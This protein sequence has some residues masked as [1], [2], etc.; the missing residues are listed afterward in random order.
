MMNGGMSP[1]MNGGMSPTGMMNMSMG[2][3]N[4][5]PMMMAPMMAPMGSMNKAPMMMAP[6]MAPM[7]MMTVAATAMANPMLSTLVAALAATNLTGALSHAPSQVL[8]R[9]AAPPPSGL[10]AAGPMQLPSALSTSTGLLSC[11]RVPSGL[12]LSSCAHAGPLNDPNFKGTVFA[13]TND[14]FMALEKSM[15]MTQVWLIAGWSPGCCVPAWYKAAAHLPSWHSTNA[16]VLGMHSASAVLAP[17]QCMYVGSC[18]RS[19]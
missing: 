2:S 11:A 7:G 5:A 4:K 6:M 15:N 1:M 10:Q 12:S 8:Q 17:D 18:R 9:R 14:A 16:C 3:M 13:P 19:C